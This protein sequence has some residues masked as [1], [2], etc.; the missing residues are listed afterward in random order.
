[1]KRFIA[2]LLIIIFSVSFVFASYRDVVHLKNG[3]IIKGTII[4]QIPNQSIKIETKDGNV[5]VFTYDE[6]N[7]ITKEREVNTENK[8]TKGKVRSME[9]LFIYNDRKKSGEFAFSLS[10]LLIPGAGHWYCGEVGRGFLFLGID[11]AL[12]VGMFTLGISSEEHCHYS[13]YSDW[14]YFSCYSDTYL[15]AFF[16]ISL[17][18]LAVSRIL[19][20]IDDFAAAERHNAKL[21]KEIGIPE[22]MY[23][24]FGINPKE[25][26]NIG[27]YLALNYKF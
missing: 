20:W 4:E 12:I 8:V 5:F 26:K 24:S 11:A 23:F 16:Y 15:N 6:V 3:G 21:R 13:Y 10:F 14:T 19:E 1:M 2:T 27:S 9:N 7:K 22:N 17:G 25:N 18:L